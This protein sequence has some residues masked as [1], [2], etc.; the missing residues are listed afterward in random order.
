[1]A[2]DITCQHIV[3][4]HSEW[5]KLDET[6]KVHMLKRDRKSL[7][8]FLRYLTLAYR[9]KG[10]FSPIERQSYDNVME[11]VKYWEISKY[12]YGLRGISENT[13]DSL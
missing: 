9:N 6:N 4:L 1:M 5:S 3:Q 12:L 11:M 8:D 7:V 2:H 10:G 13:S